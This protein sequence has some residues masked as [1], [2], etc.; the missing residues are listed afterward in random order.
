M[1]RSSH[2]S[3]LYQ[4]RPCLQRNCQK[5]LRQLLPMA[6]LVEEKKLHGAES[7]PPPETGRQRRGTLRLETV[8]SR[9]ND[10]QEQQAAS[11][12]TNTDVNVARFDGSFAPH[13]RPE[14]A[15]VKPWYK[16]RDYFLS[17]WTDKSIWKAAVWN[18]EPAGASGLKPTSTRHD[19]LTDS[20]VSSSRASQRPASHTYLARSPARS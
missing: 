13:A 9:G 8:T 3:L 18:S 10:V 7:M 20:F 4:N 5:P 16:D 1:Q 19:W 6:E 14:Q 2:A 12:A 11:P 17:G 15:R